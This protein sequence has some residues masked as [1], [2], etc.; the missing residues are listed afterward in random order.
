MI[1]LLHA[2]CG[3][4][5]EQERFAAALTR[6]P[7]AMR[8]EIP[9]LLRWQDRQARLLGRLLLRGG[10]QR[11]GLA[12][13]LEGWACDPSGRPRLS[14]CEADFSISHA[15][16]L[17]LCAVSATRRVGVDV[18]RRAALDLPSL[19]AAFGPGE[20]AEIQAAADPAL[21]LLRLWT[22]KEAALKADGRGLALEPSGIDARG[23]VIRLGET[24][25]NILRPEL[26]EGWVCGLA[27]DAAAPGLELLPVGLDALLAA[28]APARE[29]G[30]GRPR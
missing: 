19:R 6:L 8:K 10:L 23:R 27:T 28:L 18:E 12:N 26:G 24:D 7:P 9:V 14:G 25:W 22:A 3:A 30:P 4:P 20:W 2:A 21:A 15:N 1:L 17:A 29:D 11:L 5:W 13:G 16:G